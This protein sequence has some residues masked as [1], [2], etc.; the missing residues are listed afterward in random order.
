MSPGKQLPSRPLEWSLQGNN[1]RGHI[2]QG[3]AMKSL[4]RSL[5]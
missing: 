5:V 1:I 3:V 2:D 4:A